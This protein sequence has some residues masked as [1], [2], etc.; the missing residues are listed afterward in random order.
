MS[1]ILLNLLEFIYG[2]VS[3][4]AYGVGFAQD[5]VNICIYSVTLE[6]IMYSAVFK[7]SVL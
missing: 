1:L 5:I 6:K 7:W 2:P 4:L 3:Y